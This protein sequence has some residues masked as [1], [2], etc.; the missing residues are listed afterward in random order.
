M[1]NNSPLPSFDDLLTFLVIART[2]GFRAAAKRLGNAPSTVSET[3]NRLEA[4]LGVPL[5]I[6]TTRSVH[7][8]EVGRALA[9]RLEPV[10][11]ETRSAIAEATSSEGVVRGRLKL[12]VPGAVMEDILPPILDGFARAN[13]QVR[14]EILVDDRFNDMIGTGCDAGIRYGEHLA[15]DMIAIPIGPPVQ[16]PALAAAPD[17]LARFGSPAHPRDVLSHDCIRLRFASG[18]LTEWEFEK[19]GE[20]LQLDPAARLII[21]TAGW[22]AAVKLAIAG[23]GLIY[24]FRNW[25]EPHFATGEL[26]PVLEDWCAEYEGPF[27]YYSSRLTPRPLRAFIDFVTAQRRQAAGTG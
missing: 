16:R 19:D 25:L 10:V 23:H 3:I 15:Q 9:E 1:P 4:E 20:T 11:A 13:P 17:Y 27:L 2:G 12:Q 18:A 22:R 5:I 26:A 21:G 6:R 7:L 14:V 8:T 24:G